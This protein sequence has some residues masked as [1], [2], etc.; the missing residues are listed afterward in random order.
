MNEYSKYFIYGSEE[1][2]KENPNDAKNIPG[3]IKMGISESTARMIWDK[4][5]KFA[6]YAFN[7]SHA[8]CY[9]ALGARTAYLACHYP[10]E[11][12]TGILNSFI[13]NND[14]ISY[15]VA[16]CK[17]KG[18]TMLPPDVNRSGIEFKVVNENGE[19]KI[20]FGLSGIKGV[21][22]IVAKAII[23]ERNLNGPFKSLEDF[24]IRTAETKVNKKALEALVLTGG[25][26]CF[27][28][29]NRKA[30][31]MAIPDMLELVK[32]TK[33][34]NKMQISLFE[35]M[36][37]N[38]NAGY[39]LD[40]PQNIKD[41]SSVDIS[42]KE[43]DYLGYFVKHPITAYSQK[44]DSW[45]S[46]KFLSDISDVCNEIDSSIKKVYRKRIAGLVQD[47]KIIPYTDRNGKPKQLIRFDLNDETG[48]I[49]CV[50]FDNI[51]TEYGHLINDNSIIYIL[52]DGKKDDFGISCEIKA[53]HIFSEDEKNK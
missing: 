18:I 21:G 48:T 8:T 5:V 3:C 13:G 52:C 30:L 22:D 24:L 41:Y 44:L 38:E 9:A 16:K 4:M 36:F 28:R 20:I 14:K 23:T 42:L 29:G 26:E 10:I 17:R 47:K 11:Y 50:G 15:Y 40:I 6:S 34:K 1:H 45:R 27:N 19:K 33:K 32:S 7:K 37:G 31:Y 2:D 35:D 43:K 12:T 49:K 53:V 25:F 51:V 39:T 46:K